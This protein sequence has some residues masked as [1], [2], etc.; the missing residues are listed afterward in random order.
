MILKEEA[1]L[2]HQQLDSLDTKF[3]KLEIRVRELEAKHTYKPYSNLKLSD[4]FAEAA[5]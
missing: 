5:S 3:T 1:N 4:I 2:L